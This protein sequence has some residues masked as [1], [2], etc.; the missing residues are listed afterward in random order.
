MV[1]TL[2]DLEELVRDAESS[3]VEL[4]REISDEVIRGLST[5]IAAL[6]NHEGGHIVF[7]FTD[8]KNPIGCQ[9]DERDPSRISQQAG[10]CRPPVAINS[11]R[12]SWGNKEFLVLEVPEG[13]VP[14]CDDKFRFPIRIGDKTDYLDSAGVIMRLRMKGLLHGE[15]PEITPAQRE[16]PRK[17]IPDS[18]A[19]LIVKM[20]K[21]ENPSLRLE[22]LMDLESMVHT[23]IIFEHEEIPELVRKTLDSK[24]EKEIEGAL[25]F[26]RILGYR[27]RTIEKNVVSRWMEK[28]REIG[29]SMPSRQIAKRAFNVLVGAGHPDAVELLV[30]WVLES[31]H[32]TY[33]ALQPH[34]SLGN[35]KYYGLDG[36]IREAMYSLLQSGVEDD[37]A[38]RISEILEAVRRSN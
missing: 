23:Y 10:N 14:H 6:A 12:I 31:D 35:V 4:K 24:S 37:I 36:K 8:E 9:I 34:A 38:D 17:Q 21:S 20:L 18:E 32:E 16:P 7:G 5:D 33:L 15:R 3:H 19:S 13:T 29:K 1:K 2:D 30:F 27:G 11:K 26:L 28:I 22:A 25:E